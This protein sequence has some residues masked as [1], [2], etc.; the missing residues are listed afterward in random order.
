MIQQL[1]FSVPRFIYKST[2]EIWL[3]EHGFLII[4]D[5]DYSFRSHLINLESATKLPGGILISEGGMGKSYYA[6]AI[7]DQFPGNSERI[8]LAEFSNDSHGL[9]QKLNSFSDSCH[10][11]NDNE[12]AMI[13]LD[14]LDEAPELATIISRKINDLPTNLKIWITSRDIDQIR[15]IKQKHD[16]KFNLFFLAPLSQANVHDISSKN[17]VN[18]VCFIEALKSNGLLPMCTKPMGVRFAVEEYY[19]SQLKDVTQ[20]NIWHEGIRNLCD[21]TPNSSSR[22]LGPP[23]YTLDQIVACSEWIA[24]NTTVGLCKIIWTGNESRCPPQA[25]GLSKLANEQY[26]LELLRTTI[27]R[28]IFQPFGDGRIRFSHEFYQQYLAAKGFLNCVPRKNWERILF[29]PNQTAIYPEYAGLAAWLAAWNDEFLE[30]LVSIS[31]ETV[32]SSID[33]I[34]STGADKLCNLLLDRASDYSY[35]RLRAI[36]QS[37]NFSQLKSASLIESL[38]KVLLSSDS[39]EEQIELATSIAEACD[40]KALSKI[41][42]NRF[43]DSELNLQLRKDAGY[44]VCKLNV[45]ESKQKLKSVLPID[46]KTDPDDCLLEL[47]LRA[48]W[49]EFITAEE[50]VEYLKQPQQKNLSGAYSRFLGYKLMTR[51][52]SSASKDDLIALSKWALQRLYPCEPPDDLGELARKIY[53]YVWRQANLADFYVD[54]LI[55]CLAKGYLKALETSNSPFTIDRYTGSTRRPNFVTKEEFREGKQ[56]RLRV[57]DSIIKSPKFDKKVSNNFFFAEAILW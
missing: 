22:L 50:I 8:I 47:A 43:L 2:D 35:N 29:N 52:P 45:P 34:H 51:L 54:D 10:Q 30:K 13:V 53:S 3:D 26:N 6:Q 56:L 16:Q 57:L 32:L 1:E 39:S 11:S 24:L 19:R 17:G 7:I 44:A 48:C 41:F 21:E 46:P 14:G 12:N 40:C 23:Q 27:S 42:A 20:S 15:C 55:D 5:I 4:P 25:I 33:A 9:E 49:P 28:G 18:S 37:S 38:Q 31:P 36:A